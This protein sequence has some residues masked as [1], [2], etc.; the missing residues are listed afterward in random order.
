MCRTRAEGAVEMGKWKQLVL[1]LMLILLALTAF[2][3]CEARFDAPVDK[4]KTVA[5]I[6]G[7]KHGDYWRTVKLG[8]Q[9]AA[10]EFDLNLNFYAPD[11]ENDPQSQIELVEQAA[12]DGYDALVVAPS[13][14]QVMQ[15]ALEQDNKQSMPI[16][17]LDEEG[18][19]PMI[20]SYV[21]TDN[22][23]M[24]KKAGEKMLA[25]IGKLGQVALIGSGEKQ[26][27]TKRREQGVLDVMNGTAGVELVATRYV[28]SDK[29]Q[30]GD[31]AREVIRSY[32]GVEGIIALDASTATRVAA[33]IERLGLQGKVKVVA[34]DSPPEVLEYL[35]EGVIQ[36]TIIQNPFSMGYL[37]VKYALEASE[38]KSIPKRLDTGTKV[39]DRENMFWSENQK[40]LFPFVK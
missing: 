27:N 36:A 38:G 37:G 35:Q 2:Y 33:E 8:A 12:R 19:Y 26:A 24:G 9:M 7:M 34:I 22:Y 23:E 32:P 1:Y 3:S 10:R 21:G 13:D 4:K 39:I 30:A 6:A 14:E 25:I 16:L 18:E 20:R 11:Y 40:L 5:L 31:L 28:Q 15:K 17:T 29:R